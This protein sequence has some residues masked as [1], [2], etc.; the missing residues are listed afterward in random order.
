MMGVLITQE[1]FDRQL[2]E[3]GAEAFRFEAQP[4]YALGYERAEFEL[5]LTGHPT[6]P[7]DVDWWQPWLRQISRLVAEGKTISRVR[8]LAEPPTR[9]QQWELWAAPWH[10][11]A[12]ED[13]RYMTRS[14]AVRLE[15]PLADDWW[16]LDNERLIVMRHTSGGAVTEMELVTDKGALALHR[17][18]RNLAVRN[19]IPAAQV[20]AA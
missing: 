2:A 9:Y 3:F 19:A 4:A 5:F 15:L 12:G 14:E 1:E 18:W 8:V 13:I 20:A 7:P 10:A 6:P 17:E 16:L 11:Q